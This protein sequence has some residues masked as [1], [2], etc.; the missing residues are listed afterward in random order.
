M[1]KVTDLAGHFI[2]L[3]GEWP[4]VMVCSAAIAIAV[5]MLGNVALPPD[6]DGCQLSAAEDLELQ[7]IDKRA[8]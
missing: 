8:R 3:I 2:D 1:Q 5:Y 6:R 4:T 7:S